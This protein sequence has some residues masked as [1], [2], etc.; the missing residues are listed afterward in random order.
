[1]KTAIFNRLSIR[2][3]TAFLLAAILGVILVAVLAY[4]TTSNVFDE[5]VQHTETIGRGQGG[6]GMMNSPA[7]LEAQAQFQS[8]TERN[9]WIAGISGGFLAILL[10]A[11]FTRYIV[12]PLDRVAVAAREVARGNLSQRVDISG[13]GELAELGRSFNSMSQSLEASEQSRRRLIADIAHELRT[14]LTVIEGTVDSII[15]GV[16]EPDTEHL[17][18]IK[19]QSV[20]LTRLIGDLR[21]LSSAESGH[22]ELKPT[23]TN[24]A[25]LVRRKLATAK[26][27]ARDKRINFKLKVTGKVPEI[28]VDPVRMEQVINN[29]LTNAIRHTPS[30]GDISIS[31]SVEQRQLLISVSDNGEGIA[32]EHLPHIFERFYRVGSSRARSQGGTGLGLAIVKQMVEAHGGHVWAK[33]EP[34]GGSTFHIALPLANN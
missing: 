4:F 17:G 21:D 27:K 10:G 11:L 5:F 30:G 22:L 19:E 9:L 14:P 15:D 33:S 6:G 1:M 31:I 26:V 32:V 28:S 8:D 20:L 13:S 29:L 25:D 7:F 3:T 16:F 34:G 23:A 12:A 24:M 18:S 2:L